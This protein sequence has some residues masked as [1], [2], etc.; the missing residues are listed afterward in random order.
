MDQPRIVVD[1]AD[2]ALK[3]AEN[4][5]HRLAINGAKQTLSSAY[6]DLG[7]Y[8]KAE[9]YLLEIAKDTVDINLISRETKMS[10]Y[11]NLSSV[12]EGKKDF[13]KSLMYFTKFKNVAKF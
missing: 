5:N 8:E 6:I 9:K 10:I 1:Y 12:Y 3:I 4:I 2:K 7:Q 11:K 13:K